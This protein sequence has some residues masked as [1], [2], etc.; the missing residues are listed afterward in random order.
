MDKWK[1]RAVELISGLAFT[2][3]QNPAVVPYIPSKTE[4]SQYEKEDLFRST[5]E[6]H[7]ISSGRITAMLDALEREHRANIH[8]IVVTKDGEVISECSAPGYGVNVRHLSHSMSKTLTGMAIGILCDERKLSVDEKLVNI[9]PEYQTSDKR[10]SKI[11]VYNA[12]TMST[13]VPFSELGSVTEDEWTRAYFSSK[14]T[15][16]PGTVFAYNS[17]NSYI[18]ARTVV[19]LSGMS[20]FDFLDAHVFAPLGITNAFWEVGPEGIEK[21]G[22]GVHLSAESWAKLGILMMNHGVYNGKRIISEKWIQDTLSTHMEAPESIGEFNYGY[23][24]WVHR[25]DDDFLFS[26]MLGQ[27]VWV[28]PHNSIVVVINS[29]NNELFQASPT[30]E[31]VR[32]YLSGDL[33][34][35]RGKHVF[36]LTALREKEENFYKSRHWVTP[37]TP[38]RGIAYKLGFRKA[39]PFI[40]EWNGILGK[41]NFAKNNQSILPLFI[42]AM[43]NNYTGGI[44]SFS[45]ERVGERLFMT[46]NEGG[47][48]FRFEVGLYG[49]KSTVLDI[50]GEKYIFNVLGEAAPDEDGHTVYKIDVVLPE[51][52]NSRKIKLATTHDG[53]LVVKMTEQPNHKLAEPLVESIY[54]TNPKF[55]FAVSVLE[56]RLGDKFLNRKLQTLF[57]PTLVGA[58][59]TSLDYGKIMADEKEKAARSEAA[60]RTVS[61]LIMKFA[62]NDS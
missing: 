7:G 54:A 53:R 49:F 5:P 44:W 2:G 21:G 28:C 22:W 14:L 24:L 15:F 45:F 27:N 57:S 8:N 36:G 60:T 12:L 52:P 38:L 59:T 16:D 47:T 42:R 31:I 20:L 35:E 23:H 33:C 40:K 25:D 51:M 41:Y 58:D 1:I 61:A 48:H 30:I 18:L 11:S 4:T 50:N 29:G 19:R 32:K 43:Q 13:G 17:M 9:F 46:S 6:R 34:E 55:A 37:K 26:G 62:E 10:F 56:K 39:T 3:K